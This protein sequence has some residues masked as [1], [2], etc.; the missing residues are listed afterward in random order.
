MTNVT[1]IIR[2][3]SLI[4][5]LN[6]CFKGTRVTGYRM[7]SEYVKSSAAVPSSNFQSYSRAYNSW[8]LCYE[9]DNSGIMKY[10]W[11]DIPVKKAPNLKSIIKKAKNDF[12][13][14]PTVAATIEAEGFT[15]EEIVNNPWILLEIL[16]KQ[17]K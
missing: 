6:K 3:F 2:L 4:C 16:D 1:R 10:F 8:L 5:I 9:I 12:K 7:P 13:E 15:A 17:L 11:S 14:Y